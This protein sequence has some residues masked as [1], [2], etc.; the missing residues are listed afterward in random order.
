MK[1]T[2]RLFSAPECI[3]DAVK[4]IAGASQRV[5]VMST[6]LNEDESTT[7][8]LDAL[9]A[10]AQR[11][12]EVYVAGDAYTFTEVSG[13]FRLQSQFSKKLRSVSK[14]R[15]SF[16]KCGAK[17][18]WLGNDT[19]TLLNG[20]THSK[21]IIV[22]DTVYSFGGLNLYQTGI[23]ATDF[24]LKVTDHELAERLIAEHHRIVSAVRN[25]HAYRS[26]SFGNDETQIL[27]DGGF[28][29]DSMIYRHAC[30]LIE[31][32]SSVVFVSQYCPNGK[33]GRLLKKKGAVVYF[34][35]WKQAH[36]LNALFIRVTST[37][38]GLRTQ[39]TRKPYIHCKFIVCTMPDGSKIAITGSH[40]FA[41]GG[42]WLGTR[43]VALETRD[44]SIIKQLEQF[45]TD[46]IA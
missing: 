43:E 1:Q 13:H 28:V 9:R 30:K 5:F 4:T 7:E 27:F 20:R 11:G 10:A 25:R 18:V 24:L 45:V 12:L 6:I 35:P 19:S 38:T 42:V 29:G 33:L 41:Q 22:D 15:R 26:H 8:L 44:L 40:N 46:A 21:W 23:A 39:Y 3:A 37:L 34:N 16:E 32:A 31:E 17:F 2:F 14:L 36:S